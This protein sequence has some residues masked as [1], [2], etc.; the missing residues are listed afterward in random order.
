[1]GA[2]GKP[3]LSRPDRRLRGQRVRP[4]KAQIPV[5]RRRRQEQEPHGGQPAA[6]FRQGPRARQ[7]RRRHRRQRRT[8]VFDDVEGVR[9]GRPSARPA[10]KR[11]LPQHRH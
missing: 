7:N 1:M 4:R 2:R 9:R 10:G 3:R 6:R 8:D 5:R 11:A